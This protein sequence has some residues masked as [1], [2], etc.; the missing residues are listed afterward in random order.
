MEMLAKNNRIEDSASTP[1]LISRKMTKS[2]LDK[3]RKS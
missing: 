2:Y 3:S 1:G